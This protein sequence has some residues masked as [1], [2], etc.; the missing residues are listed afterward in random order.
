MNLTIND[1]KL[2]VNVVMLIV[3][4]PSR[5]AIRTAS[6]ATWSCATRLFGGRHNTVDPTGGSR[7]ESMQSLILEPLLWRAIS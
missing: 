6:Y 4:Q 3:R 7:A 1:V 2:R 5:K